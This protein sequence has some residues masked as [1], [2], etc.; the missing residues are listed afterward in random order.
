MRAGTAGGHSG[1]LMYDVIIVGAG[2]AGLSAALVLG[3]CR[4]RV[5]VVD[6]GRPRNAASPAIHGFLS[7]DGAAPT[8]LLRVGREQLRAYEGVEVREGTASGVHRSGGHFEVRVAAARHSSRALLFATGV[9]DR[10]PEV[11]G[12]EDLYGR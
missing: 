5:L 11:E 12:A 6:A 2:P 10:L 1:L 7:R 4:R 8:E 9:V 3:R